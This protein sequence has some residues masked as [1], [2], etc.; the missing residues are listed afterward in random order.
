MAD[1]TTIHAATIKV[2]YVKETVTKGGLR[3]FE[4]GAERVPG[5]ETLAERYLSF[6]TLNQFKASL[7][8]QARERGQLLAVKFR[9][10]AWFD[11]DLLAVELAKEAAHVD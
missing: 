7:C 2:M 9:N 3:R 10:T 8:L 6:A 4:I 11:A 5:G 1:T